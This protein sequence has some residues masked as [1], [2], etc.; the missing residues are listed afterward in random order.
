M[1]EFRTLSE[2]ELPAWY[3]HCQG[4]FHETEG[5]FQDH[6][7]MDPTGDL[8]LIFVAMDGDAIAA[9]M[10]VFDRMIWLQGRAVRMGGI[11]EV[12]TKPQ[13]RGQGLAGR[14]LEM[15]TLAMERRAM[16]VSILFGNRPLYAGH[17]YRFCAAEW[18]VA[19]VASELSEGCTLRP[20]ADAD[21]AYLIGLYDLH[22]GRLNGAII[23]SGDYW[24]RWVLPQWK[25]PL[26]VEREGRPVAYFTSA[27]EEGRYCVD[28]LCAAPESEEVAACSICFA[29]ATAGFAKVRV[30]SALLPELC[31][32]RSAED[33]AM[34]VRLMLPLEGIADSEALVRAMGPNAGMFRVDGF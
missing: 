15:S 24:Q 19:P 29:A 25:N 14:L 26:V 32:E 16:P 2:S 12:C 34:M 28:E 23:R 6:F 18:T 31:G 21:L 4:I 10:R 13:Y 8:S 9:T 3:E 22:A 17:G 7:E 30:R 11:G 20:Y 5:Y 1:I 33:D 27:I